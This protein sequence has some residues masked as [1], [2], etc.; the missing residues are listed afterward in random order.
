M[1][2]VLD[3]INE[4]AAEK[5]TQRLEELSSAVGDIEETT[6]A[7]EHSAKLE[8]NY[9]DLI[10]AYDNVIDAVKD[11]N[12]AHLFL[13]GKGLQKVVSRQLGTNHPVLKA[14]LLVL[15]KTLFEVAPDRT[16]AVAPK[17]MLN[18][19]L[20]IFEKDDDSDIKIHALD[21]LA[22]WLPNNPESQV[23]VIKIKGLES[24]YSGINT[25]DSPVIKSLL[26]L[27]NTIITE[28]VD[29]RN[30]DV[31]QKTKRLNKDKLAM[32]QRMGL[33]ERIETPTIC[34]GLIGVFELIWDKDDIEMV[35]T[36]FDLV[37]TTKPFC[38]NIL[39]GDT[40]ADLMFK[41]F[42]NV[43]N[44]ADPE[45]ENVLNVPDMRAVIEDYIQVIKPVKDEF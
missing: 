6:E 19:I 21:V 44:N 25:L 11:K 29:A 28:H 16:N 8:G 41:E 31:N 34:K 2:V 45:L 4:N 43:L 13:K 26:D 10:E 3:L 12:N 15:V 9:K 17:T 30:E 7:L 35:K 37:K 27:F 23:R 18:R 40:S 14:R 33:L 20:D 22:K 5:A 36:V 39:R 32:Y 1:D 38:V 24:F 42:L